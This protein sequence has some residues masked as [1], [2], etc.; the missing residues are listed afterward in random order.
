MRDHSVIYYKSIYSG[1]AMQD[2]QQEQVDIQTLRMFTFYRAYGQNGFP[3]KKAFMQKVWPKNRALLGFLIMGF[4]FNP[5][6]QF[7]FPQVYLTFWVGAAVLWNF[8]FL[9]M[10]LGKWHAC[11]GRFTKGNVIAWGSVV[12]TLILLGVLFYAT[13]LIAPI[14]PWF[15]E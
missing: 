14:A 13:S 9:M 6:Y 4:L 2:G 7:M 10:E 15:L 12:I 1:D 11:F 3:W 5:R 8:V